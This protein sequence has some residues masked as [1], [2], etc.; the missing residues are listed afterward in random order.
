MIY[1]GSNEP[2]KEFFQPPTEW[3]TSGASVIC[4]S[5][6]KPP[7]A[8]AMC[9][10]RAPLSPPCRQLASSSSVMCPVETQAHWIIDPPLYSRSLEIA[11]AS[12]WRET[13][14]GHW[15][16]GMLCGPSS[17]SARLDASGFA[18]TPHAALR[19]VARSRWKNWWNLAGAKVLWCFGFSISDFVPPC[20]NSMFSFP[21]ICGILWSIFSNTISR[22]NALQRS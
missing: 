14:M 22:Q 20:K 7:L 11:K 4:K 2:K 16:I 8:T 9:C 13:L 5:S 6:L 12:A 15:M 3:S 1:K 10:S 17:F 21:C 19:N 18:G